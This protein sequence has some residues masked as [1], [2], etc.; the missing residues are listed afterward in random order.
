MLSKAQV[1][2]LWMRSLLAAH[3]KGVAKTADTSKQKIDH[4][5]NQMLR[6]CRSPHGVRTSAMP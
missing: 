1:S 6:H 4:Q 3:E 5:T 2:H